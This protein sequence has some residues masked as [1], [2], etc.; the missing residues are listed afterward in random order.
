VRRL[1]SLALVASSAA[2]LRNP[3]LLWGHDQAKQ[4]ELRVR[5]AYIVEKFGYLIN[6]NKHPAELDRKARQRRRARQTHPGKRGR[7]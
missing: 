3:L 4:D 2:I 5:A 1:P 6:G 7:S